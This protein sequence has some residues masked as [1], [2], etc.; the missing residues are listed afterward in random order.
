MAGLFD[1]ISGGGIGGGRSGSSVGGSG[2]GGG[3]LGGLLGSMGGSGGSSGGGGMLGG[4]GGKGGSGGGMLAQ[5]II[6]AV[7]RTIQGLASGAI[8]KNKFLPPR[9]PGQLMG[10]SSGGG[11]RQFVQDPPVV[12]PRESNAKVAFLKDMTE[13]VKEIRNQAGIT[14]ASNLSRKES[15]KDRSLSRELAQQGQE[16][17]TLRTILGQL[18]ANVRQRSINDR[19]ANKQPDP[20]SQSLK[21]ANLQLKQTKIDRLE[22]ERFLNFSKNT[23]RLKNDI[24]QNRDNLSHREVDLLIKRVKAGDTAKQVA[25]RLG[26]IK[27]E[28]VQFANDPVILTPTKEATKRYSGKRFSKEDAK[29]LLEETEEAKKIQQQKDSLFKEAGISDIF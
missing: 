22:N 20:L 16:G 28:G 13:Q 14:G 29:Q 1:L 23:N 9:G 7:S 3:F 5:I 15:A 8:E 10:V 4:M 27:E 26:A 11:L 12:D 21:E 2:G 6:D 19:I 24:E 17:S 25:E 18:G